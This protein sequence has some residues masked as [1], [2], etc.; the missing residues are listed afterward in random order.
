[1]QQNEIK[2]LANN[3]NNVGVPFL[4]AGLTDQKLNLYFETTNPIPVSGDLRVLT[5]DNLPL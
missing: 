3:D 1:L 2:A 4:T 5:L